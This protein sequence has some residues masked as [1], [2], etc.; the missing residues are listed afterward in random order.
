MLWKGPPSPNT[1]HEGLAE[2]NNSEGVFEVG[3]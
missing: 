2:A 1:V 3:L